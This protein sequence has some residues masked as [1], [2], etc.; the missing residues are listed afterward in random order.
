MVG[1]IKQSIYKFR[2]ANPTLFQSKYKDYGNNI[3]GYKIDLTNNFRSR[4]EVVDDINKFFS[5]IMTEDLGGASYISD[6][7]M[8][9]RF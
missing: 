2:N 8:H 9:G 6:H 4:K 3:G 1:D 7:I 5:K